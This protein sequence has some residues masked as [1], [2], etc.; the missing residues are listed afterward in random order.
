LY[1]N[2]FYH[3]L[4]PFNKLKLWIIPSGWEPGWDIVEVH[5]LIFRTKFAFSSKRPK[6][7]APL[8]PCLNP[9]GALM[10]ITRDNSSLRYPPSITHILLI[11]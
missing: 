4:I 11:F 6:Y 5:T 9:G 3:E 1:L 10:W 7:A 2:V 8:S